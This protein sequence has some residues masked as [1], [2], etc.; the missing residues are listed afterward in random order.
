MNSNSPAC[1]DPAPS[2][3]QWVD[4]YGNYMCRYALARLPD[5]EVAQDIV[6]ETLVEAIHAFEGKSSSKTWICPPCSRLRHQFDAI[7]KACK[8][9]PADSDDARGTKKEAIVMPED[10]FQRRKSASR[11][12]LK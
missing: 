9:L 12:H 11:E 1:F 2:P 8:L 7:R 4:L 6:P 5:P 10:V 3:D